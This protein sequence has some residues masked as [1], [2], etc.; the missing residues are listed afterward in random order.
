MEIHLLNLTS[1]P[2]KLIIR[3]YDV[4]TSTYKLIPRIQQ[5]Y[6]SIPILFRFYNEQIDELSI[7]LLKIYEKYDSEPLYYLLGVQQNSTSLNTT[8]SLENPCPIS[9][10]FSIIKDSKN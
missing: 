6:S 9:N 1:S 2:L 10:T 7:A 5:V 8:S 3:Y 4:S